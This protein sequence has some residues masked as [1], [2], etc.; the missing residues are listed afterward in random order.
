MIL[1][2]LAMAFITFLILS[3]II[4]VKLI[5]VG[6]FVMTASIVTY[7]FTFLLSDTI[8]EVYGRKIATR[9]VWLGFLF[10]LAMVL[11]LFIG[12][13]LPGA[14]AWDAQA[15]YE[16]ILGSVPRIV[17]GSMVAYLLAQNHDVIAFH[18]W[19]RVTKGRY[20]WLRNTASTVV[21][22]AFDT[23]L[24]VTIAFAGTIPTDVLINTIVTLYVAKLIV[25]VVDTPLVYVM[26]GAIRRHGQRI[27]QSLPVA[28]GQS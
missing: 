10:S 6:G 15:G 25:A 27:E 28:I 21:S 20:L 2:A 7:P 13:I 22:Q 19:R 8:A 23:V 9:I 12:Q 14:E 18:F 26:V 17:L 4:A 5:S 3:N 24:F 16:R 11:I 1:T